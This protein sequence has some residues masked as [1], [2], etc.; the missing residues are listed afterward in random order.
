MSA[1]FVFSIGAIVFSL[2]L[3]PSVISSEKPNLWTSISTA[4]ILTIFSMTYL[5]I[6]F[7]Y[8][9]ATTATTAVLWWLLFWQKLGDRS[10]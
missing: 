1:D 10:A 5:S 8:A 6:E 9:A 3:I 4:I 2:A 7:Y